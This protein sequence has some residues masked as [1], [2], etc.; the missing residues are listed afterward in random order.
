MVFLVSR[1]LQQRLKVGG[2]LALFILY[3]CLPLKEALL[4]LFLLFILYKYIFFSYT[5]ELE[6]NQKEEIPTENHTTLMASVIYTKQPTNKENSSLFINIILWENKNR[7]WNLK[8]E[9]SRLFPETSTNCSF[10]NSVS[11]QLTYFG[12]SWFRDATMTVAALFVQKYISNK[13]F[14]F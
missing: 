9:I 13:C 4:F 3:L 2:G 10:M 1:F 8:S 6:L 12:F 11:G 7:G 14:Y 5:Q